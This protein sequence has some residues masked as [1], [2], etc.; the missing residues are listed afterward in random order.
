MFPVNESG[1]AAP[2]DART[3]RALLRVAPYLLGAA[4]FAA[5]LYHV[6]VKEWIWLRSPILT[7]RALAMKK[8]DV[9]DWDLL[10]GGVKQAHTF[11]QTLPWW[12]STWV[13]PYGYWR[14]LSSLGFWL[15]YRAYGERYD[16]WYA[17]LIASHIAF[18]AVIGW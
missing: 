1:P 7:G 2:A 4:L 10:I 14:P 16:L 3:H 5:I 15:E 6:V 13:W 9:P 12:H 18:V 8:L 17:T 11:W